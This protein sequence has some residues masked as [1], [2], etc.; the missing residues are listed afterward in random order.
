[1]K[2]IIAGNAPS[3]K[4]IDYTRMPLQYDVF[5]CNQF[6]FESKYYLGKNLK[7]VFYNPCVFVEQYYTLKKMIEKGEYEVENI[8]CSNL[9][10]DYVD[11]S[12][13]IKN[14]YPNFPDA[15]LG[16]DFLKKLK[17]FDAF[18]KYRE[19]YLNQRITSGIYMCAIAIA[20]GYKELYLAG[21]DFY[22]N[23]SNYAF[24]TK[25]KN[26]IRILPG[27][28]K[29]NSHSAF[30]QKDVDLKA[31]E[32]LK[33]TYNVK[34]YSLCPSS[35]L[36]NFIPPSPSNMNSN[37][38]LE[39]KQG[40]FTQDILL[41][42]ASAYKKLST[43]FEKPKLKQNIY[44]KLIKDISRL[45]SDIKYFFREKIRYSNKTELNAKN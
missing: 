41:P 27:F 4:H 23:G 45:P 42:P 10:V 38:E 43:S 32:F 8:I 17:E 3:L 40:N 37:F 5:R 36:E 35:P 12:C 20:L 33:K 34:L 44:Y 19:I 15:N 16:Y 21:I 2:A 24:D 9:G 26:L 7:A 30:H 18:V 29:A 28:K 31:L 13:F 39:V 25:Q 11:P 6:Y 22:N 14:F 1:M